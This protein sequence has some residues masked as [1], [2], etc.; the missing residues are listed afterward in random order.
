LALD[1]TAGAIALLTAIS[2][3]VSLS[4][5]VRGHFRLAGRME[6]GMRLTTILT[7][8][9]FAWF[10]FDRF[11]AARGRGTIPAAADIAGT[12]LTIANLVLFWWAVRVTRTRRLTLAFSTDEPDFLNT[13]GPYAWVRHPFYISY[14][15]FWLATALESP[16][17]AHW[18]VPVGMAGLYARAA[19]MEEAK[20]AS[21]RLAAQYEAYKKKAGM[22]VPTT[23]MPTRELVIRPADPG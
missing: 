16:G 8:A 2:Y 7:L 12:I 17:W 14:V 23:L 1:T 6:L 3:F 4:W 22:I 18:I 13:A 20:F 9:A 19:R 10:L 11:E 5:G 21:S 15:T